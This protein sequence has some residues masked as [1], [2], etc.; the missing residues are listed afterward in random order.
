MS[1]AAIVQST[2]SEASTSTKTLHRLRSTLEQSLRRSKKSSIPPPPLPVDEYG[3]GTRKGKEKEKE[4]QDKDSKINL[5]R[6]V[7]FRRQSNDFI[8]P[9]LR[10]ASIS[11]P[12]LVKSRPA[13]PTSTRHRSNKSHPT[14]LPPS[15]STPTLIRPT[16]TT[17]RTVASS[18]SPTTTRP[19]SP[20]SSSSSRPTVGRSTSASRS[21]LVT[22]PS[23]RATRPLT[24]ASTSQLPLSASLASRNTPTPTSFSPP[25]T[26][27]P[28]AR[29]PSI[30]ARRASVDGKR[31]SMD[32]RRGS[33]D[34][35]PR[36]SISTPN[37]PIRPRP[38]AVSPTQRSYAQ[39][40]HFNISSGSLVSPTSPTIP[41]SIEGDVFDDRERGRVRERDQDQD[42]VRRAT[43]LL[44]YHLSK[45]PAHILKNG[46]AGVKEWG[47]VEKRMEA[48]K[49]V[50]RLDASSRGG[51][52]DADDE[53]RK[54]FADAVR[55]GYVL[56]QLLNKLNQ[57]P[58]VRPS[59]QSPSSPSSPTASPAKPSNS[60]TT[61]NITRFLAACAS[62]GF[63]S[64][65]LFRPDD[66]RGAW[67][68]VQAKKGKET[69]LDSI[70]R[71]ARCV[72]GVVNGFGREKEQERRMSVD[73]QK[74][75]QPQEETWRDRKET[76]IRG[77][78]RS[79]SSNAS[80]T[81]ASK[82]DLNHP[83]PPTPTAEPPPPIL[84]TTPSTRN[85]DS[86]SSSTTH[87]PVKDS[88]PNR[89]TSSRA[90]ATTS[91]A[92][93]S[94]INSAASASTPNLHTPI[95]VSPTP[96]SPSPMRKRWT[97]R[98]DLVTVKAGTSDESGSGSSGLD[99]AP[100][101]GSPDMWLNSRSGFK[102]RVGE[103]KQPEVSTQ[104]SRHKRG[105]AT[106][107]AGSGSSGGST[108]IR[109]PVGMR[110]D[111]VHSD[112][113]TIN[114]DDRTDND[115]LYTSTPPPPPLIMRP[116][117]R[118]PLR[119]PSLK[120]MQMDKQ[121]GGLRA[122]AKTAADPSSTS[123]TS[124]TQSYSQS[125][126]Y[127]APSSL[128]PSE[129]GASPRT[130]I[131]DSTRASIGDASVY[132]IPPSSS[133]TGFNA[134][135]SV[136]STALSEA[137]TA[138]TRISSVLDGR[139]SGYSFAGSYLSSG[140]AAAGVAG[141][142]NSGIGGYQQGGYNYGTIRTMTTDMTSEGPSVSLTKDEGRELVEELAAMDRQYAQSHQHG[143]LGYVHAIPHQGG[144]GG[145]SGYNG[146]AMPIHLP[147]KRSV[148][149]LSGSPG[150]MGLMGRG[151][152]RERKISEV[153]PVDLMRV[154]EEGDDLS[155]SSKGHGAREA[156]REWARKAEDEWERD[157]EKRE[158]KA[159][160]ELDKE[161]A[162][163][164]TSPT[165]SPLLNLR[166]AIFGPS[167]SNS[168]T[169]TMSVTTGSATMGH[170]KTK[171][172]SSST[173]ASNSSNST[174]RPSSS[175]ASVSTTTRTK[176]RARARD[177][178][179][180]ESSSGRSRVE[181]R[182]S[183][184]V[185]GTPL[186]ISSP[187]KLAIVRSRSRDGEGG[188]PSGGLSPLPRRPTHRPRQSLD[189]S[190]SVLLPKDNL[191]MREASPD[192]LTSSS[193]SRVMLRRSHT[194]KPGIS[195]RSSGISYVPRPR[196]SAALE[197]S[198]SGTMDGPVPFPRTTSISGETP[199]PRSSTGDNILLS[200]VDRPRLRGRFQSD[201][202][203]SSARWRARPNSYDEVG[204]RSPA[205]RSR[206]ESMV[207]LGV[208]SG[209]ASASDLMTRNSIDGSAVRARL[210]VKEDGKPP[211]HF[212]LGNCIGRGQFGSV[213][214]ALNLNTGQMVAVKRIR[215]EGLKEEEV[216]QLMREVDLV[217]SL[218]HPSIVKYEGMARDDDTL[219]IV[220]EYAENGS[221]G[222]TL[223]A[224]GKLN[225]KLV[226]SYVVKI[227]E[228][229]HYLHT[230]D[231]VHCD[232]K[233]ANILTTKNGN[234]KLSDFGVSL[235]LRAMGG[236]IK[237]VAG[238]PNWMAP[239]VIELKGAS[240]KSDIW[241]LGCTVI[242]LLTGR[243]PYAEIAN[244]MSG[245]LPLA[246][247]HFESCQLT[248]FNLTSSFSYIAVMFRIVEDDSPPLP[249]DCSELLRDFLEQCFHKEPSRRPSAEL[250]CEHP[251]LKSNWVA[252]Q[253]ACFF[254]LQELRPQD[255]IPFLRRVST[256]LQKVDVV[257]YLAGYDAPDSP[258]SASP[259]RR[260]EA[261]PAPVGRRTSM[262][263]VRPVENNEISPREH[264]FVKT[265]FSKP[266]ICR[267]CLS[268]VKKT[269]V[270]C[271]Q[272]SLISHSKC[273]PNAPPTC[274]LRAQLLLYAQ[275]AEKGNPASAYS[276]PAE[277]L[278]DLGQNVAL[279]DVPYVD[280]SSR[281]GSDVP[282]TPRSPQ[283]TTPSDHGPTA[284]KFM[285]AFKRSR[286]NLSPESVTT[287]NST[288]SV[289]PLPESK[290]V[291][292]KTARPR[293]IA[294]K[295]QERPLSMTS[296]STGIS[297][298]RSAATAAESFSSRQNTA[299][300]AF[301]GGNGSDR[302]VRPISAAAA[303]E[304]GERSSVPSPPTR[305]GREDIQAADTRRFKTKRGSKQGSSGNCVVQ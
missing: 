3:N 38:R 254:N 95:S 71:I 20:I 181:S 287:A 240:T 300:S 289:S 22:P 82:Y 222:Q 251:W 14:G 196:G 52:E 83:L 78:G 100:S 211:T 233:A 37:T 19:S 136:A 252:L 215:L 146:S 274:D 302:G 175:Q 250:L 2:P 190:T 109:R 164:T 73:R 41:V 91:S 248:S 70:D 266:M 148:V 239:E 223:K 176:E 138:S 89:A 50:R 264:S 303:L 92:K 53:M 139:M 183:T 134:R 104:G 182:T 216:T 160:A 142:S 141:S 79:S 256:D 171:Q 241:S 112:D 145:H 204:A 198:P 120:Q 147:K 163:R 107:G 191:F 117:P 255:S 225:E 281:A 99:S 35:P 102:A 97:P 124:R 58:L 132:G 286:S 48:L 59:T 209:S 257:R 66:P 276:N 98:A 88:H 288:T 56:C 268:N 69:D 277:F 161:K 202:E 180:D 10:Q 172:P 210:V 75:P 72:V 51:R 263:S 220:L 206:F 36:S 230:S 271:S 65:E 130:S 292:D 185:G 110:Y 201:I 26:P 293:P 159:K 31:P 305:E 25:P 234:V 15:P 143:G 179:Q 81:V 33:I 200:G 74:T 203:G 17:T 290:E 212:Q 76:W 165:T 231:V 16:K 153:P 221:L 84:T 137:E 261:S 272:C 96:T 238:T 174:A 4:I 235:N 227:L 213:Y 150:S 46:D 167:Q 116:P 168:V 214:R 259:G 155:I 55:D 294:M 129:F 301:S 228:G 119:K 29:R 226:A 90:N 193:P 151:Y 195:P 12:S 62:H 114:D 60:P 154:A 262:S 218:S 280:T 197:D 232:L 115:A 80:T 186:S 105:N 13:I 267:V 113:A 273:A 149:E 23:A 242:E 1:A 247:L 54:A 106:T 194:T 279:S 24:S 192:S 123:S 21:R 297:S 187:R 44:V 208:A 57:S 122:W 7:T 126:S 173:S 169:D 178:D 64:D 32:Q 68:A 283:S 236:E 245:K 170:S 156:Q 43:R 219:S 199:S 157:K 237:D 93:P 224:F 111:D 260:A 270:L 244:S 40:R 162:A 85:S 39:N 291:D 144:Y 188:S 296:V 128:S 27:T 6:K 284:F 152:S 275:Y 133:S 87:L 189:S 205:G 30:D 246:F 67:A 61:S 77:G 269:A 278:G 217:K 8:T 18:S 184:P 47:E 11:S 166:N 265:T 108:D 49:R 229:L 118:S 45:P 94:Q 9:S 299:R 125:S 135:R 243:P 63:A 121:S 258:I 158:N 42:I 285:A 249:E 177:M 140:A 207:N 304:H 28:N 103:S 131:A 5:L 101:S 127:G 295:R 34:N 298:M 253:V 282:P 86:R